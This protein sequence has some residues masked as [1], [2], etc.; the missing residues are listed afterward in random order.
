MEQLPRAQHGKLRAVLMI[1]VRR[2]EG[3]TG[4]VEPDGQV[5]VP[6]LYRR[7]IFRRV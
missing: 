3:V 6:G 1:T 4:V 7:H 5:W 2:H